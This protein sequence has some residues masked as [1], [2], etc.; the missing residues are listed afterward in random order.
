[1]LE[2]LKWCRGVVASQERGG[3]TGLAV[4]RGGGLEERAR[5]GSAVVSSKKV[6]AVAGVVGAVPRAEE[7]ATAGVVPRG[8]PR[9]R[10][11]DTAAAEGVP[12]ERANEVVARGS[13]HGPSR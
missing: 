7:M 4:C 11:D 2:V 10:D 6:V 5:D 3:F 13:C 9:E 8:P 1:M 12:V